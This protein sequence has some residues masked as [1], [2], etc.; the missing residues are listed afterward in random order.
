ML[1]KLD[2]YV[3]IIPE[4]CRVHLDINVFIIPETCRVNEHDIFLE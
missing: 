1:I 4:T 3:F 2:I